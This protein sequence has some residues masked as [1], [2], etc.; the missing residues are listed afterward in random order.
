MSAEQGLHEFCL[1]AFLLARYG[2]PG[3]GR[4]DGRAWERAVSRG[5]WMPYLTRRQHAG[6]LGVFGR[7]GR[8]GIHH[9]IDGI[10]HGPQLGIWLE[11]KAR[12]SLGKAD[13]ACFAFK[14]LDLYR[15]SAHDDPEVTARGAWWTLLVSSDPCSE[16]VRRACMTTGVV[17]CEPGLLPLPVLLHVAAKPEA[18]VCMDAVLL[19][20][21]VRLG[22]QVCRPMQSRWRIDPER[23]ELAMSVD[24]PGPRNLGDLLFVQCELTAALLDY[25]ALRAPG[26]LERRGDALAARLRACVRVW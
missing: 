26:E 5:L 17:L 3:N 2:P 8:S 22:E 9:E 23:R 25:Y 14:A 15:Q 4:P 24:E 21:L 1:D 12:A 18:D 6:T 7:H 10:G 16:V 20:E 19:S 13:V 11:A